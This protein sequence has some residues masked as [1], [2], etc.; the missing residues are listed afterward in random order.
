M[1]LIR[2]LVT[3]FHVTPAGHSEA[4]FEA[5]KHYPV[6]DETKLHVAQGIA[7]VVDAPD[8][9]E[10]AAAAAESAEARAA[11]AA[12]AAEAARAAADAATA[13]AAAQPAPEVK[14]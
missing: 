12:E 2:Y 8:D 6:T 3:W 4:K 7:E 9:A 13:A 1:Q 14:A 10:K 11:K 5:G